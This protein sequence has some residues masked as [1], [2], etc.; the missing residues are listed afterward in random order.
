[1]DY[2]NVRLY[3]HDLGADSSLP[4]ARSDFNTL[5]KEITNYRKFLKDNPY[6]DDDHTGVQQRARVK[7]I[8]DNIGG[9]FYLAAKL[10]HHSFKYP[11]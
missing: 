5:A 7:K 10:C 11:S 3:T 6:N 1:M 2:N 4:P 9:N 8:L